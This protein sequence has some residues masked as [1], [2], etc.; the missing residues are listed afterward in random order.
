MTAYA[1]AHPYLAFWLA[2]LLLCSLRLS[3]TWGQTGRSGA[4]VLAE[5]IASLEEARKESTKLHGEATYASGPQC[6][7]AGQLDAYGR[8]VEVLRALQVRELGFVSG[9]EKS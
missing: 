8:A 6:R 5:A 4:K 7:Y 9:G 2:V 1:L 3:F